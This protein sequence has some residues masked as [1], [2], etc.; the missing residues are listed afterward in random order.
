MQAVKRAQERKDTQNPWQIIL[1]I[2]ALKT[3]NSKHFS[4]FPYFLIK[5]TIRIK[6]EKRNYQ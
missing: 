5:K 1:K 6:S 4:S 2:S 3:L